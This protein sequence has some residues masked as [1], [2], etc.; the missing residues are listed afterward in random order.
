MPIIIIL[1]G[2]AAVMLVT[3]EFGALNAEVLADKTGS[4]YPEVMR[5]MPSGLRG[6]NF[7]SVSCSDCFLARLNDEFVLYDLHHGP[8]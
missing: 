2:I 4:A 5:I 1:S 8:L 3:P 6:L 7:R